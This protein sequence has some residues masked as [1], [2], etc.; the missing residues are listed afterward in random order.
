M[1]E[2]SNHK[3]V[4]T[5]STLVFKGL[6]TVSRSLSFLHL[7]LFYGIGRIVLKRYTT[8]NESLV[9]LTQKLKNNYTAFVN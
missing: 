6:I 2:V 3:P 4:D 1:L 5:Q 9:G 8:A 7:S